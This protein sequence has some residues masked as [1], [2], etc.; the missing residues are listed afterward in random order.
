LA[1]DQVH[2]IAR[3]A[4]ISKEKQQY[5]ITLRPGQSI[6]KMLRTLNNYFSSAVSKTI[7]SYD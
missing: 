6:R 2:I 4:Q 1:K 7:K 5:I 3:T